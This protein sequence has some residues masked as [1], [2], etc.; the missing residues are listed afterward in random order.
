MS[1]RRIKFLK[2][3]RIVGEHVNIN[4]D[5]NGPSK[6]F[7]AQLDLRK[8][9]F[10]EEAKVFID[11]KQIMETLRIDYG[12]VAK[13]LGKVPI[14]VSRL[15]GESIIFNVYVVD[16]SSSRKLG[17]S[18]A[19][20]PSNKAE[21]G[22]KATPLL[23]VDGT[24][25]LGGVL[26]RIE[27]SSVDQGGSSDAPVLLID[28]RA[29]ENSAATFMQSPSMAAAILPGAM[30]S[31]LS[32]IVL[33]EKHTHDSASLKWQDGWIRFAVKHSGRQ[34]EEAEDDDVLGPEEWIVDSVTAFSRSSNLLSIYLKG[35]EQ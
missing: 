24:R 11:A 12:T 2:R 21:D 33:I 18:L 9:E 20:R 6:H 17:E 7:T 35:G 23:P 8:Y 22:G 10:P 3:V 34:F 31:I 14:D 16:P 29:C 19:I 4:L 15:K 32:R 27:Y 5:V 28:R 25:D 26:W 1:I 30:Q 13:T